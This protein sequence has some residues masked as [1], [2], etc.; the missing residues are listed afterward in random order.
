M[1]LVQFANPTMDDAKWANGRVR[2]GS[3]K[4]L[5]AESSGWAREP[6]RLSSLMRVPK[7]ASSG[8]CASQEPLCGSVVVITSR[9]LAFPCGATH[10]TISRVCG[11]TPCGGFSSRTLERDCNEFCEHNKRDQ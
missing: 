9:A 10:E 5:D 3:R 8:T 1:V 4:N 11:G 7:M 6:E 2:E